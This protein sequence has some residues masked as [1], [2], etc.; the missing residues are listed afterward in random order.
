MA[1][2][3]LSKTSKRSKSKSRNTRRYPTKTSRSKRSKSRSKRRIKRTRKSRS[4]MKKIYGVDIYRG[5]ELIKKHSPISISNGS[6]IFQGRYWFLKNYLDK[7]KR[8]KISFNDDNQSMKISSYKLVFDR[9]IDYS[10]AK[11]SLGRY[12]KI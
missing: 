2:S 3:K 9:P 1:R 4:P 12:K 7:S 8:P 10:Y 6:I 5:K 11:K